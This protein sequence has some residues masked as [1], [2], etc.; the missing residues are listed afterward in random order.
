MN[1]E[2]KM[3]EEKHWS[4]EKT[5]SPQAADHGWAIYYDPTPGGRD[6]GDGT[7]TYSMS[8]PALLLW[9]GLKDPE[10]VAHEIAEKLNLAEASS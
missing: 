6:N 4:A 5:A 10:K 8:F 9:E 7:K 1:T 3:T 2:E